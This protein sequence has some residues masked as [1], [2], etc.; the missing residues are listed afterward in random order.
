DLD[1]T[2]R[3]SA[4]LVHTVVECA[5]LAFADREAWYGDPDFVDVPLDALLSPSYNDER[6]SLI[7]A[8]ASGEL[9]PGAADG[10]AP[11]LPGRGPAVPAGPGS[12]GATVARR[13]PAP[14]VCPRGSLPSRRRRD[15]ASQPWRPA[16]R[17]VATPAISTSP[18][19]KGT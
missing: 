11:R 18:T 15:R 10:R 16:P 9:R 14:R 3:Q 7:G 6:R 13:R 8:T 1:S 2:T 17:T 19:R 4:E 12:R 5:K